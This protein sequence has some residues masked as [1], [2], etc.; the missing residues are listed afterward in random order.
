MK[1]T[2][3]NKSLKLFLTLTQFAILAPMAIIIVWTFVA[4][5]SWPNLLPD[6]YSFRA[7]KEILSPH[8]KVFG[9]LFSSVFLSLIVAL[10]SVL[11]ATMTARALVFYDF[12]GKKLIDFL[13]IAPI[14][15]PA[16]VFAM[17][18]HVIFI[19][20]SLANTV[21]GVIIVHLIY[22]LPYSISIMKDL[23]SS[24]I[25]EMEIQSYVLGVSPLKS[26]I[27][28]SLPLLAPGILTSITMA[29]VSSFSQYFLTLFIGG[30]QVKSF[31][32]L[33]LPFIAKG[34]RALSS[35]YAL[36]FVISTLLV[37]LTIETLMKRLVYQSRKEGI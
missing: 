29:Y 35:A 3:T 31:N 20:L 15:V 6:S 21:V 18:I 33:M 9:T 8:S 16:T 13:S 32:V 11:I 37:F 12:P 14:L 30:G 7:I 27:Y 17:G 23:T 10:L 34:D 2:N 4:R 1:N 26:F 25:K 36:I 19:K 24:T 28:I 22:S 5:W